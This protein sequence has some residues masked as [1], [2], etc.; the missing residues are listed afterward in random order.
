[1]KVGH[2][3][4]NSKAIFIFKMR[5]FSDF[6]AAD[7]FLGPAPTATYSRYNG[8]N[9]VQMHFLLKNSETASAKIP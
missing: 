7:M 6:R 4:K 9:A 1:V 2:F 3:L 5:L 8:H